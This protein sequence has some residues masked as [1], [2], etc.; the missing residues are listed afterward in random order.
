MSPIGSQS[1]STRTAWL[2]C[3]RWRS[4]LHLI[5]TMIEGLLSCAR[6]ILAPSREDLI[7]T[8]HSR[9]TSNEP[10]TQR[11]LPPLTLVGFTPGDL[12]DYAFTASIP[13][14]SVIQSLQFSTR[15]AGAFVV[16]NGSLPHPHERTL[17]HRYSSA[18]LLPIA[19]A[20]G[21]GTTNHTRTRRYHA[22]HVSTTSRWFS[23][24]DS[25]KSGQKHTPLWIHERH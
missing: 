21:I 2:H 8:R 10:C 16:P 24:L 4:C 5:R 18:K 17:G 19:S 6:C 20:M 7:A 1:H 15:E 13:Q 22:T 3:K 23:S 12:N 11:W 14:M 9:Y 25:P